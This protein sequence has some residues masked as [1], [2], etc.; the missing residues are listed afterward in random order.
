MSKK[1]NKGPPA[2]AAALRDW[3]RKWAPAWRSAYRK[4]VE[5]GYPS[6]CVV[7]ATPRSLREPPAGFDI[8]RLP[9]ARAFVAKHLPSAAGAFDP[10][11]PAGAFYVVASKA[12]MG[13]FLGG[14]SVPGADEDL[15]PVV[16][17]SGPRLPWP[18]N[19]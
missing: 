10:P 14:M 5:A 7:M 19:N 11:P 9:E 17:L 3:V 16:M 15:P 12:G 1:K 8:Q 6:D 13:S 4:A 2:G 18:T